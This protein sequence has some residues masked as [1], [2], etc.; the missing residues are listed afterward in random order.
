MDNVVIYSIIWSEHL[1]TLSEVLS[2]FRDAS[3]TLNTSKS[4]F[5]KATMTYFGKQVGQ[6]R[7]I[8]AKMQAII[9]FPVPQT[10]KDLPQFLGMCGFYCG[11]CRNLS[12][13]VSPLTELASPLKSFLWPSSCQVAF[14]SAKALLCSAPVLAAANFERPFKL[15]VDASL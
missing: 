6:M 15:E 9:D 8:A 12:D 10:K 7:P 4:E 14:E 11:L 2:R 3:L 13:V 5:G 1:E